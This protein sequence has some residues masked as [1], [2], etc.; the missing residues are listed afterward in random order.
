MEITELGYVLIGT[1]DLEKWRRYGTQVLGMAEKSGP[2]NA[3]YLKMDTRDFRLAVIDTGKDE[4]VAA[5]WQV[6]DQ[7]ELEHWRGKIE[8]AGVAVTE[9]ASD[10]KALRKVNNFVWFTDPAGRRH[11][12]FWGPISAYEPFVSPVGV[13]GFVT[14][15]MGLGHV[16]LATRNIEAAL[17]FWCDVMGFGVSDQ[18]N[19]NMGPGVPP[20]RIYFLHCGNGRQHSLA[21]AEMEAPTGVQHMMVEVKSVDD[22]GYGLDRVLDS[23]TPLALSIGRHINDNMLSFYM[24]TPGGF[25]LEYG[26]GG[27]VQDWTG[28]KVFQATK[29]SHWGHRPQMPIPG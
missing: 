15:D 8:G 28:H 13:S 10:E 23:G 1:P 21:I 5:G 24:V 11:E 29:G 17:A 9:G 25:M 12:V 26:Y 27:T 19:F 22:V 18:I 4:F 14:G 7:G 16:V 2:D 6:A 3:L 20:I